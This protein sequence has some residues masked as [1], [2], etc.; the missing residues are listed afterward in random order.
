[1]TTILAKSSTGEYIVSPTVNLLAAVG[2]TIVPCA[3]VPAGNFIACGT[4]EGAY[5]AIRNNAV[6][7]ISREDSDNFRKNMVTTL[8]EARMALVVQRASLCLY[9]A[10]GADV[11]TCHGIEVLTVLRAPGLARWAAG[12]P[13]KVKRSSPGYRGRALSASQGRET[14]AMNRRLRNLRCYIP[15]L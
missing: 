13:R 12:K 11:T 9:G 3:A 10:A 4:P 5:M 6:V 2:A 7:E 8:V 15:D 14:G 1:L